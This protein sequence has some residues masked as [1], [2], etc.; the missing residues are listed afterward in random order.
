MKILLAVQGQF[1]KYFQQRE[2]F[3]QRKGKKSFVFRSRSQ[4][5]K[6]KLIKG[7]R[8]RS[9]IMISKINKMTQ[10]IVFLSQN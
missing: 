8:E 2:N 10:M 3:L 4:N 5:K 6:K 1:T 9:K 7:M